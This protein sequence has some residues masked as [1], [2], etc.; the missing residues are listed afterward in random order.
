MFYPRHPNDPITK[1]FSKFAIE[2]KIAS[3]M[4]K[5][6]ESIA[7]SELRAV[8]N[9][10]SEGD[11]TLWTL[12]AI[13]AALNDYLDPKDVTEVVRIVLSIRKSPACLNVSLERGIFG[14]YR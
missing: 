5:P 6:D 8:Y 7:A 4:A 12:T 13:T 1:L 2:K 9:I 11:Q 10:A 3:P 14:F